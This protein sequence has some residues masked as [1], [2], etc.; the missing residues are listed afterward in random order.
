MQK[1]L[2]FLLTAFML[3]TAKAQYEEKDFVAYSV[4][5]GLSENY[6][7]CLAQDEWGYM[8]IGTDIGLNRF[9]GNTF[10]SFFQ[11]TKTLPLLS[12]SIRNLKL[13]GTKQLGILNH[14][15][16]QLLNT[17]DLS[18][19]NY[20]IP[21]TTAFSIYR[22]AA[23]DA[24][25]LPGK[26]YGITTASGFYVFDAS[27][28][29]NFRHDAYQLK[30]IGQK[31]IL[32]GRDIFP[33]NDNE[34]LLLVNA[35]GLAHYNNVEKKFTEISTRKKDPLIGRWADFYPLAPI[36]DRG[37]ISYCQLNKDE[38]V[39]HHLLLK[40][41]IYYNKLLN[42]TVVTPLT[43]PESEFTWESKITRLND[44]SFLM[45]G[46]YS[47]FYM[48]HIN[49]GN[50]QI[51]INTEKFLA[52][53]KIQCL[54]LDKDNRLWAGTSKG[55]LQQKLATPVLKSY[56]YAAAPDSLTGGLN[57]AY[58]YKDKLYLGRFSRSKGLVITDI[59]TGKAV[60]Q[61][62]FY[63]K[64]NQWN[65]IR[66]IQ[67]YHTDTL[68]IGTNGGLLWFNTKTHQYG[69]LLNEIKYGTNLS[70]INILAPVNKD[71]YAWMCNHLSGMVGRYHIASRTF[72]FFSS[73]TQPALPFGKVKSIAYDAYGDVWIGGHSLTRWNTQKQLFDTLI[74]VYGGPN[75]YEDDILALVADNKGS[76]WLHNA[77][78]GL[79][80]Y[81]IKEK[82]FVN[83]SMKD[84]LPSDVFYSFSPV[85]NNQL[86]MAGHN[87]LTNFNTV[88]KKLV[89]Y[90]YE[91]G[92]PDDKPSGRYLYYDSLKGVLYLFNQH[93]L[94]KIS[95]PVEQSPHY[96]NG[97]MIEELTLNN[98]E[99]LF[100]PVTGL[101]LKPNEN[102]LS[103]HFGI[104]N[105]ESG[106]NY[107]F[108]YKLNETDNWTDLGD[109]RNINL[110]ALSPGN[111]TIWLKGTGKSGVQKTRHFSF[112]IAP[113]F[114]K[115]NWF[116]AACCLLSITLIYL[117]YRYRIG[118]IR[119]KANIDKQ[120]S[121]AEMKAM[122]AQM[123]PHFIFNSLN[124]I[125]EMILTNENKE[126]SHFLGKFAHL[127]RMT[128]D[129]SGQSFI[130]LRTTIEYLNRYV[131]MEQ[132][133]NSY[134]TCRILADEELDPDETVLPPML[135]Q[136][137][138]EN[139][140]WHGVTSTQ[141]NININ[142]DFKKSAGSAEQPNQ[143]VCII[144]DNGIGI[145][146]SLKNKKNSPDKHH[147]VGI[148]NVNNRIHLMNEKYNLKSSVSIEDKSELPAYSGTG[149]VVTLRIPLE[150]KEE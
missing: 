103:L 73:S 94:S 53:H 140:I 79:L 134:F 89:V 12:S 34:Y 146:E 111:Y 32:Y 66:S 122:H 14:G 60:A 143:L 107:Q 99:H 123:N 138:V 33:L 49:R 115:T 11:G 108:A 128:L 98:K 19:K 13:F 42:K 141:K 31:R 24:V 114:W 135:I 84:G 75:K 52:G 3:C 57:C 22:N 139:A 121:Q 44:S 85:I 80:E 10:K 6:V 96:S 74:S 8:W 104:I 2:L 124:S 58:R 101:R 92:L 61:I 56:S 36:K 21:D 5:N 91:D 106:N 70:G 46:G 72:T 88:T 28:K 147:S 148:E 62:D 150:I 43:L 55:L 39:F 119:Q 113:P 7:T 127:I 41:I 81:R 18:L 90:D 37:L 1:A 136:P 69:K 95:L 117:L 118:Q 65:E 25:E 131:E 93:I 67:M 17:N 64:N 105:Y 125:R 26:S 9:D 120:L 132:I 16:F 82:K 27:G 20:T 126:A 149:T 29:L 133:R 23:W 48:F 144:E 145:N 142:I 38:F 68:W 97:L 112:I 76:L 63:G 40:N 4:K 47:G 110:T 51:E 86:W 83:Y 15:G 87:Q 59:G 116:I 129:H 78:N 100:Y 77:L 45:N 54:Y 30:D 35:D 71:G 137:F 130:S 50:G 109:Q 102:N